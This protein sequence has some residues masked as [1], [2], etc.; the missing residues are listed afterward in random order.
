VPGSAPYAALLDRMAQAGGAARANEPLYYAVDSTNQAALATALGTIAA[1]ITATCTLDLG[2]TPPDPSEV[3]VYLDG[4]AVPQDPTDG[5]TLSGQTITLVGATCTR[6][7]A[8]NALSLRV[9]AGCP[10]VLK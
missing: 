1:K 10:T 2:E 7:M 4:T 3:N 8:G 6:V 5:W 9:V